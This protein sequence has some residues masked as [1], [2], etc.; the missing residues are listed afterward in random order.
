MQSEEI[1]FKTSVFWYFIAISYDN[2]LFRDKFKVW[3]VFFMSSISGNYSCQGYTT[4]LTG[5]PS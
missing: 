1:L 4:G 3:R 2:I 5:N